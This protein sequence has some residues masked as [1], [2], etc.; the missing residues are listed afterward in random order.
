MRPGSI[1]AAALALLIA[2]NAAAAPPTPMLWKLSKDQSTVYLLGSMH[3]LKESDYPLSGDVDSAYKTADKLVFEVAPDD[4]TS[5]ASQAN[6]LKH[7]MYQDPAHQLKDDLQKSTW[8]ELQAYGMKSNVPVAALQRLEPWMVSLTLVVMEMQKLGIN[9]D[10]GLDMHFIKMSG[11]DHK[12]TG[13]LETTD[14]QLAIFYSLPMNEQDDLLRQTLDEMDDFPKEMTEEHDIWRHGDTAA[15]L[16]KTKK[17]FDKYP[18][19]Y[20]KLIA[21]RNRN[22]IPQIEKMLDGRKHDTLII[23]GALHLPG[24]DGVVRLLQQDGYTVERV[25]TGCKNLH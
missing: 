4:L 14:Q 19:L 21:Q 7:G 3:A 2:G 15:M 11:T 20:Q 25:C 5:P 9:P 8:D 10:S 12:A 17:D 13:G 24:K 18:D 1:C 6:A 16:A 23:V 22:W